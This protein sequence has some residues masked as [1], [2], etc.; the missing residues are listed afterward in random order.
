MYP[1]QINDMI[2]RNKK[3]IKWKLEKT[4]LLLKENLAT[5]KIGFMWGGAPNE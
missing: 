5:K 4:K 1:K 2:Q 3:L